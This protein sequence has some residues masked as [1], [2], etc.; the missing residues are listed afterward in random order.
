[1]TLDQIVMEIEKLEGLESFRIE[2][3]ST[4]VSHI[5]NEVKIKAVWTEAEQADRA[6]G[7]IIQRS[8]VR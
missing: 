8:D 5:A 7:N 1:M 2:T 6:S 4:I 3:Q